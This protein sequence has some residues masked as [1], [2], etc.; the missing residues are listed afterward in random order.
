METLLAMTPQ[1]ADKLVNTFS[2]EAVK[3]NISP[4]AFADGLFEANLGAQSPDYIRRNIRNTLASPLGN[5]MINNPTFLQ[6]SV[7]KGLGVNSSALTGFGLDL[8]QQAKKDNLIREDVTNEEIAEQLQRPLYGALQRYLK[9]NKN[10]SVINDLLNKAYP[11]SSK[12][13]RS[14]LEA[15]ID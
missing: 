9:N 4:K 10:N 15:F 14:L 7:L 11:Q 3:G 2:N 13:G 1:Q 8:L 12:G 6:P 5:L